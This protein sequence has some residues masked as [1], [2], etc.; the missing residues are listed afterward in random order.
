MLNKYSWTLNCIYGEWL[1]NQNI[2]ST[3]GFVDKLFKLFFCRSIYD[4]INEKK[5]S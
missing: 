2:L 3:Q 1:D 5:N 4:S